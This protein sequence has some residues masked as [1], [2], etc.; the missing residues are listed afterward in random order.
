MK[1]LLLFSTFLIFA[2]SGGDDNSTLTEL[3]LKGKVK[4]VD[5]KKFDATEKFGE[6]TKDEFWWHRK[7]K[8]DNKG[9]IIKEN[10]YTENGVIKWSTTI[11]YDDKGNQIEESQYGGFWKNK[12][13]ELDFK[14]EHKFNEKG[15]LIETIY[16]ES[17]AEFW[18]KD[19]FGKYKYKYD[20]NGN[21][22]EN[23]DYNKDG[24]LNSKYKYKYDDNGNQIETADYNKDG[25][26]NSKYKYKYDGRGNPIEIAGYN[27][28]GELNLKYKYKYDDKG[29]QIEMAD[30]N[31][32]G[33]LVYTEI[34]ELEYDNKAN[35]IKKITYKDD[36]PTFFSEREIEYYNGQSKSELKQ[37]NPKDNQIINPMSHSIFTRP[38]KDD[39]VWAGGKAYT[40]YD[41]GKFKGKLKT[42]YIFKDEELDNI[43]NFRYYDNGDLSHFDVFFFNKDGEIYLIQK[44]DKKGN[45][46]DSSKN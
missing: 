38:E 16:Y 34:Y 17:D 2:C 26:L 24:E 32:D 35:W 45:I 3:N 25:E 8:F 20:D 18:D 39:M 44:Y 22:I 43:R 13:G 41:S 12:G 11:K 29:N 5:T 23:A 7:Q 30:Y 21:Q 27:K 9:N 15:N 14:H 37:E 42:E 33:G 31:P 19:T 10:T 1:K 46:I 6:V 28:D 40:Y 4:S 36:K